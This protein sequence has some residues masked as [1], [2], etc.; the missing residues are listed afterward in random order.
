MACRLLFV[1]LAVL[2][3][4]AAYAQNDLSSCVA[5]SDGPRLDENAFHIFATFTNNCSQ[6][7][8]FGPV[9]LEIGGSG[10]MP[11]SNAMTL[12][13]PIYPGSLDSGASMHAG[14][15]VNFGRFRTVALNVGPCN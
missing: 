2:S 7:V 11:M 12:E 6:C 3:F 14:A 15:E 8:Q 4:S 13:Q 10:M 1:L 9:V 5:V